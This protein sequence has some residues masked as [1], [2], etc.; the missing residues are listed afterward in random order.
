VTLVAKVFA[1]T[2]TQITA[3]HIDVHFPHVAS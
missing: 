2:L 3:K 1:F